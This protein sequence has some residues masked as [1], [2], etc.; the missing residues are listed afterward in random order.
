MSGGRGCQNIGNQ[1]FAPSLN[2]H[3]H[4]PVF[5]GAPVPIKFVASISGKKVP[6]N[7]IPKGVNILSQCSFIDSR[8]VEI[9]ANCQQPH[10]K[11]GGLHQVG[12][13]VV[14]REGDGY[15][16][17]PRL[18]SEDR[19]QWYLCAL[20]FKKST[21]FCICA[22]PSSLVINFRWIATGCALSQNRFPGGN[23]ITRTVPFTG[24]TRNRM[25]K[26]PEIPESLLLDKC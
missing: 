1:T 24:H 9:L 7:G 10:H 16:R 4:H 5:C 17:W 15:P 12:A 3:V 13:I 23:H 2:R 14:G 26:L 8:P 20:F 25:A 22:K 18:T 21:V 11:V 19:L 6:F